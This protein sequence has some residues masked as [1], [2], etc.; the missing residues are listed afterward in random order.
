MPALLPLTDI[1]RVQTSTQRII[2]RALR[3]LGVLGV[4]EPIS[5][6]Q[7]DDG[8]EAF[9]D[10][11]DSWN[12]EKLIIYVLARNTFTLTAATNPHQIGPGVAAPGLDAPRPNRI[13]QGQAWLT[14]A[15]LGTSQYELDVVTREQW[16]RDYDSSLSGIPAWLYYESLFP[17]GNIWFDVKPDAAYTLVL[18]LEQMLA[19]VT[20]G[21]ITTELALPPGYKE[22]IVY[23]LAINLA[24][25]YGKQPSATVI[26]R[27]V[28]GKAS[29]KRLNMK[30][31]YLEVDPELTADRGY[32]DITSGRII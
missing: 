3:L 15:G 2:E 20:M 26:N 28:D 24:D 32:F 10:M 4:G 9:N 16:A 5:A 22:A 14:G 29:I 13:Q 17:L 1:Y 23:N 7:L 25:E 18:D 27:A 30:P 21:G 31:V 8:L 6:D 12:T 19:Q 11:L